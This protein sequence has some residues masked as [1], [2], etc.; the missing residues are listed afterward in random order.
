MNKKV[1]L[2]I[3]SLLVLIVGFWGVKAITNKDVQQGDKNINI[4]IIS[5]LDNLNEKININTDE[6]KL[7]P[8]L[9]KEEG[10]KIVDGMVTTVKD[11]DLNGSTSEYWHISINGEDAQVGVNDQ[12]IKDGDTIKFER[13]KFK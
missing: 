2:T 6:E 4:E 1:T 3:A 5:K 12:V 13:I 10:Y 11:I 7:G 8:V 9:L